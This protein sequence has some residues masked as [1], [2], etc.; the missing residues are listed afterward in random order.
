M[1]SIERL[2]ELITAVLTP[3]KAHSLDRA[4]TQL[5][6]EPD[7]SLNPFDSKRLYVRAAIDG[8]KRPELEALALRVIE[9]YSGA[10]EHEEQVEAL[11][12]SLEVDRT[13]GKAPK[14][15]IFAGTAKPVI[16]LS[17]VMDGKID[18]IEG[19]EHCLVYDR[20]IGGDGLTWMSLADWYGEPLDFDVFGGAFDKLK[21]RLKLVLMSEAEHRFFESY[22]AQTVEANNWNAPALLP[23]VALLHD[24]KTAKQRGGVSHYKHQRMDFVLLTRTGKRVILEIDGKQHYSNDDGTSS[25]R[26]YAE[27]VAADRELKLKGY[28]VYRFGGYELMSQAKSDQAVRDFLNSFFPMHGIA[29]NTP[30]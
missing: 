11:R 26:L 17:D 20:P 27:M 8:L 9:R 18:I 7:Q 3:V 6:V 29:I 23:Q 22:W 25:P 30:S 14:N 2:L 13:G 12:A 5:D 28:E 24:P 10:S 16:G 19:A 4:L 21:E 15:L 1:T